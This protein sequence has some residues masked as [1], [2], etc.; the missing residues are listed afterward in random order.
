MDSVSESAVTELVSATSTE[1]LD[2]DEVL[3]ALDSLP[4]DDK[5]RLRLLE[6]RRLAGTDFAEGDLLHEAVC[7]AIFGSRKCP[8]GES[9]IAFLAES[10]RSIASHRRKELRRQVPLTRGA[11]TDDADGDGGI[12]VED[13]GL[14]PE[15]SLIARED[16]HRAADVLADL[17]KRL[18]EDEEAGLVLLG[19]DEELR[20]KALRDAVGVDQARLDYIIKRIRR[21]ATKHYPKGWQL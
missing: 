21:V 6:R 9:F 10:M 19:W 8:R 17:Q 2:V 16:E 15:E 13:P 1:H 14:D 3:L 18:A 7:T 11:A 5:L 4:E 20:G 12:D